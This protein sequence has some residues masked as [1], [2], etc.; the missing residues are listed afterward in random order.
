MSMQYC[1]LGISV[2]FVLVQKKVASI[3]M[4]LGNTIFYDPDYLGFCMCRV[5]Y[6]PIS[7]YSQN[8]YMIQFIIGIFIV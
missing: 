2:E 4:S 7:C 5:L 8:N 6:N 3:E 1:R